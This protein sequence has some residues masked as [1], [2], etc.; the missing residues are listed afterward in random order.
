MLSVFFV[1]GASSCAK[2]VSCKQYDAGQGVITMTML[3]P[4]HAK[5]KEQIHASVGFEWTNV[6]VSCRV[7]LY[8]YV[9]RIIVS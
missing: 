7:I 2:L 4:A 9:L 5:L 8:F 1:G 3:R 6:N